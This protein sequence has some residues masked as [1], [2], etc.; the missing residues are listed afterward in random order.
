MLLADLGAE[1]IKIENAAIG[2]DPSR[3]TGPFMLGANDSEYYQ[4]F[5]INKKSVSIDLRTD[6]GKAALKEL[7]GDRGR[8]AQQSPRRPARQ[9]GSRLQVAVGGA[10]P[11]P[12][13]RASF[14]LWPRQRARLVA[15]LR[16]SD[17][18]RIR[19]DAPDRR[20]GPAAGPPR[21]AL[22]HR[23]DHRPDRCGRAA[24]PPSSRRGRPARA[25]TSIPACSTSR[26]ISLATSRP[27]ISTRATSRPASRRSAHYSVAPVQTFPTSD[28]WLFIMCMTDKFWSELLD[29]I[30]QT[31]SD[32][33]IRALPP[34]RRARPT[35]TP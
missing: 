2:G 14:G 25:A 8:P 26:C 16:L 3:K 29:G 17:A 11:K 19:P 33:P 32:C 35:A 27:G 18:G 24:R 23:P 12:R 9:A 22:D 28:G 20:A 7:V 15:R 4:A 10:N 21:R 30:G 13:L 1:V 31:G 6:E 5:N 34:S